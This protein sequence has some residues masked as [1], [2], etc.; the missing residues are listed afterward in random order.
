MLYMEGES[1]DNQDKLPEMQ[2]EEG[3]QEQGHLPKQRHRDRNQDAERMS[4]VR[5]EAGTWGGSMGSLIMNIDPHQFAL[6]VCAVAWCIRDY[7]LKRRE[8]ANT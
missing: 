5:L 8:S 4:Q 1:H 3:H 6:F 2:K 7:Q